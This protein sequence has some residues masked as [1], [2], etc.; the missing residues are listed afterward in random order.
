QQELELYA[1]KPRR[2]L[3]ILG[4]LVELERPNALD[5]LL[6]YARDGDVVDVHLLLANERE[7]QVEWTGELRQ[8]DGER[9]RRAA[10]RRPVVRRHCIHRPADG[11]TEGRTT[12]SN[13][14]LTTFAGCSHMVSSPGAR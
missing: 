3:E 2:H 7:E 9:A 5:K 10:A 1:K 4:G 6:G 11:R 8:I 14:V 12:S 13:T